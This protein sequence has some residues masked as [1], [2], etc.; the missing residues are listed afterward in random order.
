MMKRLNLFSTSETRKNKLTTSKGNQPKYFDEN[1]NFIKYDYL[2]YEGLSEIICSKLLSISSC[3]FFVHY[4]EFKGDDNKRGCISKNFLLPN[5]KMIT[6][7]R[8]FQSYQIN[9]EKEM[10]SLNIVDK[11]LY[12]ANKVEEITGIDNFLEWLVSMLKF[13]FLVLNEDR[14]FNNIAVVYNNNLDKFSLM[15]VFDNGAALLSDLYDYPIHLPLNDNVKKVHSKP[16]SSNFKKQF[17]A[18]C[19]ISNAAFLI[20]YNRINIVQENNFLHYNENEVNR[21]ITL[22][23]NRL[24]LFEKYFRM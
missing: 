9:I 24:R 14:H 11:I 18:C 12:V 22:L 20:D 4:N 21:C 15:P 3:S 7:Y 17:D 13:D 5:Q 6:L 19:S 23:E 10:Q 1:N 8:L 16:F 2:G